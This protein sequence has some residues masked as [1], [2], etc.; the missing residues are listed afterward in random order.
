MS[1]HRMKNEANR[2]L[3]YLLLS[4]QPLFCFLII[5]DLLFDPLR[6]VEKVYVNLFFIA[7]TSLFAAFFLSNVISKDQSITYQLVLVF[8]LTALPWF[9]L[10]AA[11][12]HVVVDR[13]AW[14]SVY[15]L[16]VVVQIFGVAVQL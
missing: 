10:Q 6:A 16:L 9:L 12:F 4:I 11:D 8:Y 1:R 14:G 7:V 15:F 13:A 3:L 5:P 2:L